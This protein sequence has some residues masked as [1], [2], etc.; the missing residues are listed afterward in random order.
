MIRIIVLFLLLSFSSV[1][2]EEGGWEVGPQLN[3]SGYLKDEHYSH[4]AGGGLSVT[5]NLSDFWG[6]TSSLDYSK[7]FSNEKY[8][9]IN[10]YGGISYRLDILRLVPV[11][12]AGFSGTLL[13][14]YE[15]N[16]NFFSVNIYGGVAISYL[17]DWERSVSVFFRYETALNKYDEVFNAY[18]SLGIRFNFIFEAE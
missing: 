13:N 15:L 18:F 9:V 5:Y 12:E 1:F 7:H 11:I 17:I 6:I 14:N 8:D 4:G 2:A 3:Y 16:D 10:L